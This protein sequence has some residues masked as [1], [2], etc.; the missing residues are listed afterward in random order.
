MFDVDGPGQDGADLGHDLG[1]V[2][3]A[4]AGMGA[5]SW[6]LVCSSS[7][8]PMARSKSAMVR[9]SERSSRTWARTS[10]VRIFNDSVW[11][12]AGA[13]RSRSSRSSELRRPQ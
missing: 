12:G 8:A 10:S 2:D 9:S 1:Q 3:L 13:S 7:A 4:D 5:S 6:A 11:V